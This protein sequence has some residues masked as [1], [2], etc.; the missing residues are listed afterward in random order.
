VTAQGDEAV[1]ECV[2]RLAR[3]GV[4]LVA[5]DR[6]REDEGDLVCAAERMTEE[7]MAFFLRH[8]SGMVCTPMSDERADALGLPP[9]VGT[10][11]SAVALEFG[12]GGHAEIKRM[13]VTQS[14]R[15]LGVGRRLLGELERAA[16]RRGVAA[17]RLETNRALG[18]AI[19]LCRSAGYAEMEAFNDERY[20]HHWF[21]KHL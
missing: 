10:S 4:V 12:N 1:R 5:D 15:G 17:L 2:A 3:G 20:A 13:W 7:M 8:G 11:R 21:E 9:M 6:D 14:V 16:R 18:E 19:G